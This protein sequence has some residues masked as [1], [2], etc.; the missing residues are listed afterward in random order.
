MV[1]E[2]DEEDDSDGDITPGGKVSQDPINKQAS[3][4]KSVEGSAPKK[5]GSQ[6]IRQRLKSRI[7]M[8]RKQSNSR[9][10]PQLAKQLST[11]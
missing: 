2:G 1:D 4:K 9:I 8:D 10:V 11:P 7:V 6:V 5:K 3:S